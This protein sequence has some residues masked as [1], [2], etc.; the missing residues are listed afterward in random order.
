MEWATRALEP[1]ELTMKFANVWKSLFQRKHNPLRRKSLQDNYFGALAAEVLESRELLSTT[2]GVT[3]AVQG[4]AVTLTSTDINN[5]VVTVTRSGGNVVVTGASGT[6]ITYGTKTATSQSVAIASV[7]S[8]TINLQTGID[9]FNVTGLAVTGNITINGQ[10]S[11]TANVSISA[12]ATNTTIGGSIL[13]NFGNEAT[14]FGLFGSTNGGGN[15]TVTGAVTINEAGASNHQVNIYGPPA[16]NNTGGKLTIA[17]NVSVVDTGNGQSGLHIDDGVTF[18]GNVSFDNSANTVSPD[19]VQMFSNSNAFGTTSIAG[20]LTLA[21]SQVTTQNNSVLIQ[22]F[23]TTPL[24]VTGAT[25]ITSGAGA[26]SIQLVNDW[27]KGTVNIAT[28]TVLST[29]PNV[30]TINGSRFDGATTIFMTGPN[31]EMD[32]GTDSNSGATVFNGRL[33]VSPNQ[34]YVTDYTNSL[35]KPVHLVQIGKTSVIFIDG[36]GH[37]SLGTFSSSTEM[38]TPYFPN[39]IATATSNFSK[40]TWTDGG[41]WTQA[42]ATTSVTISRYTNPGGVLVNLIQNTTSGSQL[43]IVDGLGRATLGTMQTGNTFMTDLYPG[44]AATIASNKI[45]WQDG[46]TWTHTTG[47]PLV[48]GVSDPNGALS[49]VKLTSATA[50]IGLDGA[51]QGV[52]ATLTNG[53]LVWSNGATWNN[54]S[55]NA[56]TALFH[57]GFGYS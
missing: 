46:S 50:L 36:T 34:V 56:L 2:P 21:L 11:G 8:L 54:F 31:S 20:S 30:L 25:S 55:L 33:I 22:G 6:L 37:M 9:T 48:F 18:V 16:N 42:A 12:G 19:N 27:F 35:G 45:T 14:T 4:S 51:M 13:A 47:S 43:G 49:R 53:S 39:D 44:D 40:I 28:G 29:N 52:T 7:S 41:V 57:S 1:S 15:L 5:P 23:G 10:A 24:I 38:S 3:L 32:L 17:G 26:D